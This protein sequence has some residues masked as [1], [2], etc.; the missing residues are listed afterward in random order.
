MGALLFSSRPGGY[1]VWDDI[2][3]TIHP[4]WNAGHILPPTVQQLA[5]VHQKLRVG[6]L[7]ASGYF[8]LPSRPRHS[9]SSRRRPSNMLISRLVERLSV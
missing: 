3:A 6:S 7:A 5:T 4:R 2:V 9:V 1:L 8:K